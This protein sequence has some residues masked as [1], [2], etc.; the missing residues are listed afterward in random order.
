MS[1][2]K[3]GLRELKCESKVKMALRIETGLRSTDEFTKEVELIARLEKARRSLEKAIEMAAFGDKRAIGARKLCEKQLDENLRSAAAYV[4]HVAKGNEK[5]ILAAGFQLRKRNNKPAE[6]EKP[7]GLKVM[8]TDNS[9]EFKLNWK[10]VRNS[11]SYLVQ[12]TDKK[13]NSDNDWNTQFSTQSRCV[14]TELKPG[15]IYSIRI[16][17]V[18]AKGVSLPSELVEIMAA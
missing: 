16:L 11:K 8:R 3:I 1:K 10:P 2:I 15:K 6:L 12:F 5:L 14:L 13:Q 4:D 9:G 7:K 18:G 17:A